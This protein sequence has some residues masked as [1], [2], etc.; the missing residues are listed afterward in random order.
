M[1]VMVVA[2]AVVLLQDPPPLNLG[3]D[4]TKKHLPTTSCNASSPELWLKSEKVAIGGTFPSFL[5]FGLPGNVS[6]FNTFFSCNCTGS[7][8]N[9]L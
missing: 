5:R 1:L 9:M 6:Y 8:Y 7:Q 2:P 4:K 3:C